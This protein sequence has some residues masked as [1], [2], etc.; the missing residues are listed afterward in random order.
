VNLGRAP[1]AVIL[2]AGAYVLAI[3]AMA[4]ALATLAHTPQQASGIA[5]FAWMVLS[6]L[7][8]AWWPLALVPAWI[9]RLGHIS[10]VAW[11]L[12]ALNELIFYRGGLPDVL[13]SVG[14][15]LFFAVGFFA[16]GV[17]RFSYQQSTTRGVTR[18]LPYL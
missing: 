1:W 7:G 3:T 10:P 9:Q 13:R 14:V 8:G 18:G 4:L 11:C 12:D 15:L 2:V 6:L 5:T 17:K 16:F